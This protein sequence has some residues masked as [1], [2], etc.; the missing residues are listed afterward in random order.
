MNENACA[1]ITAEHAP[2][3]HYSDVVM[4]ATRVLR[5]WLLLDGLSLDQLLCGRS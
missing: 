1:A 5:M 3:L 4:V 2:E